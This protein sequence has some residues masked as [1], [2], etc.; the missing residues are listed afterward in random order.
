MAGSSR[1]RTDEQWGM[2]GALAV[3]IPV[4]AQRFPKSFVAA[5]EGNKRTTGKELLHELNCPGAK[6]LA[7]VAA[8]DFDEVDVNRVRQIFRDVIAV[9]RFG[10]IHKEH[11]GYLFLCL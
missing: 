9:N 6:A 2:G 10:R 3:F 4:P 8:G 1:G 7:P 5:R 11:A